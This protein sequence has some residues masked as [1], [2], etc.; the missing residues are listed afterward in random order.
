MLANRFAGLAA[1]FVLALAAVPEASAGSLAHHGA[2]QAENLRHHNGEHYGHG[3]RAYRTAQADWH[4]LTRPV[5]GWKGHKGFGWGRHRG[6]SFGRHIEGWIAFLKAELKITEQQQPRW[7]AFAEA[8]RDSATRWRR[9]RDEMGE[10]REKAEEQGT[11]KERKPKS[12]VERLERWVT[13][14]E[15]GLETARSFHAAF[16]PLY[17]EMTVDQKQQADMLLHRWPSR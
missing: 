13:F 12:A 2:Y 3:H 5:H 10:A 8:L 1:L 15:L 9:L 17:E 6:H 7:E 16:K 11:E 4:A 14:A